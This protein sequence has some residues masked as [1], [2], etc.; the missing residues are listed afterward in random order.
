MY[1]IWRLSHQKHLNSFFIKPVIQYNDLN[2]GFTTGSVLQ[3]IL[4]L[5]MRT[6]RII[7]FGNKFDDIYTNLIE[8]KIATVFELLLCELCELKEVV[9]NVHNCRRLIVFSEKLK[10]KRETRQSHKQLAGFK[11]RV[12]SFIFVSQ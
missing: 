1:R 10:E 5:Q 2:H 6:I 7:C 4:K 11:N 3:N 9:K 12:N 8:Q